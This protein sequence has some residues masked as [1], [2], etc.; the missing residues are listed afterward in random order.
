MCEG[1]IAYR[2]WEISKKLLKNEEFDITL[3]LRMVVSHWQINKN[4]YERIQKSWNCKGH[5]SNYDVF[6][7]VVFVFCYMFSI[8]FHMLPLDVYR[9]HIVATLP[10]PPRGP[11]L[12][13]LH[14]VLLCYI[15]PMALLCYAMLRRVAFIVLYGV[16][17]CCVV[18]L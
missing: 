1:C 10:S 6:T 7:K 15:I 14:C 2:R 8:C 18:L 16:F 17:L 3:A 5:C 13:V 4:M 11:N 9:A 12:D